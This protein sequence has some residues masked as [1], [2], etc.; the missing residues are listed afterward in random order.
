MK[1]LLLTAALASA[2]ALHLHAQS[3][4]APPTFKAGVELVR[5]DIQVTDG[6]GQPVRDLKQDEV[7]VLESGKPRPV[8]FFQHVEEPRETF[9]EAARQTVVGDV[10]T[11]QGAPRGHLYVLVFDQTHIL[12]GHEQRARLAAQQF[13][14]TKLRRG[15][16]VAAYALPGPGVQTGFAADPLQVARALDSVRGLA[17]EQQ[18]GPSGTMTVQEAFQILRGEELT[19]RAV[20]ERVRSATS[21]TDVSG[22]RG[23]EDSDQMYRAAVK[24]DASGIADQADAETRR[25]LRMF[26]DVLRPMR[27]IEGR[28][29]V[30]FFSEPPS[31][32]SAPRSS[33]S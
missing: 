30:L 29:T 31:R 16:R 1:S 11:N 2:L 17:D 6:D 19:T 13:L 33:G 28:K 26:G 9:D 14:R 4:Q 10:S 15:D 18:R 21:S 8:I 25:M 23:T 7:E 24:E 27:A 20:I 3:A 22:R 12:P 32:P 5:L